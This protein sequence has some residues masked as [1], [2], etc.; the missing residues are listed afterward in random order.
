[1]D[2]SRRTFMGVSGLALQVNRAV[3][4]PDGWWNQ[5][6]RGAFHNLNEYDPRVLDVNAWMDYWASLQPNFFV[7]S[8][9]GLMAFYPTRLPNHRRS[10][11][12]GDRDV[13]GEYFKA[14][15]SRGMRVI[16]RV[17]TNWA[18]QDAL[19]ARPEWF[20]RDEQGNA[21]SQAECPWI[22]HTC[23][24]SN[25]YTEQ[26]PAMM[27]EVSSL[28]DVDAFFTNSWPDAG[29]PRRC[30]CVNCREAPRSGVQVYQRHESRILE[31]CRLLQATAGEKRRDRIY[32]VHIGSGIH[33]SLSLNKLAEVA[34]M[35]IA[36]HQ[37]RSD[38][39][40]IWDCAQQGRAAKAVMGARP[41]ALGAGTNG[42]AWRH[43]AKSP[44]E[45]TSW[46][47]Q[48]AASGMAPRYTWLGS[49]PN[50]ERW[51]TTGREFFPWLA[52]HEK[53]FTNRRTVS[54]IGVVFSQR[55]NTVYRAPGAVPGGYGTRR[56]NAP[57][58]VGD[59]SE[60][61]QGLYYALLEGRFVF[62]FVHEENLAADQVSK[63]SALLLPNVALLSDAQCRQLR[64]Y[65][66]RGGSLLA[67]FE[68]GLYNEHGEVRSEL[69][70]ADVFGVRIAGK[71]PAREDAYFYSWIERPHELLRGFENTK[72]LPGGEHRVRVAPVSQPIL[73]VAPPYP[74]GIPETVYAQGRAEAPYPGP[75]S[76]EPAV[77]L[78]E[79]G[80]S[81]V[82]YFPGDI[83]RSAWRSG[84]NDFS[85]LL[86]NALRWVTRNESPV[87]VSGEGM[88]E[89][90]A[91]ETE[92]GYA[93]H[94]LNYNNPNM[95]RGSIRKH[96]P[97]GVQQVRM[98]MPA[99]VR[100]S[101]VELLRA[102]RDA[103]YRQTGRTVDFNIPGVVDYEVAAL[104]RA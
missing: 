94:V 101:R 12:L 3:G 1:M 53:H 52:R 75:R 62:D 14:A 49:A 56:S 45:L 17:E 44:A 36:D 35:L 38:N 92:P 91:W 89:V 13:F 20:E 85:L 67:T 60:F 80:R 32:S 37:G 9:A 98:E 11:F 82:V 100:I 19:A 64:E 103:P 10:Q 68:T 7:V 87:K 47:A 26:V 25:Y 69:G 65:V 8:C 29:R 2:I 93:V 71:A 15:K 95:T 48:A 6:H 90:F 66:Y 50:D 63:Y 41:V 21:L 81:R 83:D 79:R 96:N 54:N 97:I 55:T 42:G 18:H 70:L 78:L 74:R 46:L 22:Y 58:P 77:S 57:V 34:P 28:Y 61:L 84:N 88:A 33:S 4:A 39:T 16:A 102:G 43:T 23:M 40:P 31:I 27:R 86:Q 99:G 30:Y 76:D 59:P 72:W 73:T 51:R 104:Y 5:V 24:Y